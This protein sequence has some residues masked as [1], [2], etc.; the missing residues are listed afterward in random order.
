MPSLP[1]LVS[2]NVQSLL[3]MVEEAS[4]LGQPGLALSDLEN[5][6]PGFTKGENTL[7]KYA[8]YMTLMLRTNLAA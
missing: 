1:Q 3:S 8:K 4:G 2:E 6:E 7:F 5:P